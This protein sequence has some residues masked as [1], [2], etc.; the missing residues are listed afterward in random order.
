[1][2]CFVQQSCFLS[3]NKLT[4]GYTISVVEPDNGTGISWPQAKSIA[5]DSEYIAKNTV[6]S[7]Q[8]NLEVKG[9]IATGLGHIALYIVY[10][11]KSGEV[12]LCNRNC[13]LWDLSRLGGSHMQIPQTK[14]FRAILHK[15]NV[16]TTSNSATHKTEW[17]LRFTSASPLSDDDQISR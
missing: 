1:M 14:G 4:V 6:P 8:V 2:L 17:L 13:L 7:Y 16:V 10:T 11:I 12:H 3:T 5:E 15:S 9:I